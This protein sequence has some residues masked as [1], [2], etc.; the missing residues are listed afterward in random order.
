MLGVVRGR[1]LEPAM[2]EAPTPGQRLPWGQRRDQLLAAAEKVIAREGPLVSMSAIAAEAGVSKPIVYRHFGDKNGLAHAVGERFAERLL[3]GIRAS[4]T[5][6]AEPRERTAATIEGFLARVE[7]TPQ[8]YLF[9]TRGSAEGAPA[10]GDA[11][12]LFMRR[13]GDDLTSFMLAEDPDHS[14]QRQQ[15]ILTWG[16]ATVGLIRAATDLWLDRHHVSRAELVRQ[17]T[18]IL[19][20]GYAQAR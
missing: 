19:W 15:L 9:L 20:D 6:T 14:P 2:I 5:H 1:P 11:L 17:L 4:L 10:V 18:A 12:D 16:H 13:L 8:T 3:D 7:E